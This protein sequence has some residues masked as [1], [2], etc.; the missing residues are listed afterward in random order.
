MKLSIINGPNLNLLG[1]REPSIYGNQSFEKFLTE[2]IKIEPTFEFIYNQSN[3]E[4]VI[5]DLLQKYNNDI[6]I[7]GIILN[8]GAYSHTSIAIA[9]SLKSISKPVVLVHISNVYQREIERKTDLLSANAAGII[10]GFGLSS[11][12]LAVEWFKIQTKSFYSL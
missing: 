6:N 8:A 3:I 1:I 11:Y 2:L 9:D 10:T 7:K 5:I 12:L 4:G